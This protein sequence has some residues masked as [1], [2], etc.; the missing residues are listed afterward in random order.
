MNASRLRDSVLATLLLAVPF[1]F[2][3][4]NL[5]APEETNALDRILL[6]ISAP[7]QELASGLAQGVGSIFE[8]Y[9]FLV[10]VKEKNDALTEENARLRSRLR[11]LRH[12]ADENRRFREIL[13]I[14][15]HLPGE[16]FAARVIAKETSPYFRVVRLRIDQGDQRLLRAGQ[17]VI[18]HGG[19][20]GET[21]RVSEHGRVADV[22]LTVDPR[23]KVDVR[24]RRTGAR[25]VLRGTGEEDRYLCR[26]EWLER[27][28]EVRKGDEVYT[29]GLGKR[30]PASILVGHV[31]SVTDAETGLH[32]EVEVVPSVHFGRLEEVLVM[33]TGSARDKRDTETAKDTAP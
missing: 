5:K 29:S 14:K 11:D 18:S 32:Q 27:G 19:L 22:L 12:V 16:A 13:E 1:F 9:V 33:T 10:E 28:D 21:E 17:A 23:A 6:R 24:I 25:G 30:F 2:L 8:N 7:V 3:N 31:S 20:V 15:H 26:I 4:A